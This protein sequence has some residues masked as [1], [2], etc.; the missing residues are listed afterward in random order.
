MEFTEAACDSYTWALNGETY[1]ASG[2][3]TF[4]DGCVT[5]ILHL[6]I[7]VS[8]Y[9]EYHAWACES[10]TWVINGKTYTATGVYTFINNCTTHVLHLTINHMSFEVVTETASSTCGQLTE[11][12][13]TP[14]VI[15]NMLTVA[16]PTSFI[17]TI[18]PYS[19]VEETVIAD[20]SYTW[21]VNGVTYTES[22]DYTHVDGCV[23]YILHLTINI[24]VPC[25]DFNLERKCQRRLVQC[26]QLDTCGS[27][28]RNNQCDHSWR[29]PEST[30]YYHSSDHKQFFVW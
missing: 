20:N 13:I 19:T 29:Y 28:L 17:L 26:C 27:S 14:A 2:D 9:I 12:P 25:P 1:D 3:F 5:Y 22:G 8:T 21:A 24:V 18:V 4:V 11:K 15:T 10:Y 16:S 23:T 30:D 6:T 7:D